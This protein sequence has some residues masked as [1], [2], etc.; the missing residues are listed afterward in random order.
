MNT[1]IKNN[2]DLASSY[3]A[4]AES[5]DELTMLTN[6]Q[7]GDWLRERIDYFKEGQAAVLDLGCAN[8][9][10]AAFMS[11]LRPDYVFDG[12]DIS[13]A[14]IESATD[15]NLYRLLACANA[16]EGLPDQFKTHYDYVTALAFLEFIQNTDKLMQDI[17]S[18]LKPD[19]LAFMTFQKANPQ[20]GDTI[21]DLPFYTFKHTEAFLSYLTTMRFNVIQIEEGVGYWDAVDGLPRD[22]FFVIAGK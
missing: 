19:G 12:L 14:M 15:A 13:K 2:P 16:G 20:L 9:Y 21:H 3:D 18:V 5:Y 4:W 10:V 1:K 17:Q 7:G 22:Y 11:E 6:Y 8:G